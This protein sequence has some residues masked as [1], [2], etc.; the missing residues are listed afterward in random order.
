MPDEIKP[1]DTKPEGNKPAEEQKPE[2]A[3]PYLAEFKTKEEA[4]KAF[5]DYKTR[6]EKAAELEKKFKESQDA[7]AAIG[8]QIEITPDGRVKVKGQQEPQAEKKDPV[9]AYNENPIGFIEQKINSAVESVRRAEAAKIVGRQ[10]ITAK[11]AAESYF[12]GLMPEVEKL[13]ATLPPEQVSN[14]VVWE[15]AY[16]L[17]KSQKLDD[18]VK[19]EVDRQLGVNRQ[20][21][22]AARS[23]SFDGGGNRGSSE[24]DKKLTPS[25]EEICRKMGWDPKEY[26]KYK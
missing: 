16:Q 26:A 17:A 12:P 11:H 13:M 4:E 24:G 22:E 6:A 8:Q 23:G 7:L 20:K 2:E 3:K 15:Q 19:A 25:E 1:E 18:I 21:E 5:T 10:A 14:P 9:E